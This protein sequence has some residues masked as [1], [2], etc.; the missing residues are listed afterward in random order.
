MPRRGENIYKRKD[1]R[2]EGRILTSYNEYGKALYRSV[3]ASNYSE[4]KEK[5]LKYKAG[6]TSV[7]SC[8][9]DQMNKYCLEWLEGVK[10]KYKES[11]YGK[12]RNIC[13]NHIIP[14]LGGFNIDKISTVMVENMISEK[15][16]ILSSKTVN[17][18]VSVL[19]QIFVYA[20]KH[21]LKT[22]F[23]FDFLSVHQEKKIMRVLSFEE[24]RKLSCFLLS[25]MDLNKLGMYLSLFTGIRI[26]EL[27]SLKWKNILIDDKVL[28]VRTTMQRIQTFNTESRTQ[29]I[30]T[31]PKSKCSIRDIPLP[32]FLIDVLKKFKG[33]E[34][35]FL[36]TGK[37]KEFTE[38]RVIQYT[39]K[40]YINQCELK[41]AN[42]HSLR[43]TF[44]T[45]CVEAGFEIKTLSEIL[46]HSSVSI[47][48]DRYVHSS[49][50]LKRKNMEKLSIIV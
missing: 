47:T 45:R 6:N 15:L 8:N 27:C 2:W 33:D 17:D 13:M 36:L 39:F 7:I 1:G 26:G 42:F 48:L 18:I 9:S 44:A 34:E 3:Y 38:P 37:V 11:T 12:Y 28:Q 50:E 14:G 22:N 46:G 32:D 5:M 30:I 19:K 31:S 4:V 41:D 21:G 20:D 25:D 35:A 16:E 43:H 29:V 23:N 49:I 10:L 40:K 24:Q